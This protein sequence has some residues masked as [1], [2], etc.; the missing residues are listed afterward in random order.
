MK[1]PKSTQF[2]LVKVDKRETDPNTF[3]ERISGSFSLNLEAIQ[4][5]IGMH[6]ESVAYEMFGRIFLNA[7]KEGEGYLE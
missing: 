1:N 3:E 2:G 6:G 7:T 5:L 4:D